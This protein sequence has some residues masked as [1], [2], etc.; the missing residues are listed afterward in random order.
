LDQ[1][2]EVVERRFRTSFPGGTKLSLTG[3]TSYP[4]TVGAGGTGSN[5][6]CVHQLLV[7]H[8]YF[9]QLHQQVVEVDSNNDFSG[10]FTGGTGGSGG[11]GDGPWNICRRIVEYQDK[12]IQEEM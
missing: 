9:Q 6:V 7:V 8:Q 12:E 3:G 10:P 1:E 2:E 5:P 4:I 11:G